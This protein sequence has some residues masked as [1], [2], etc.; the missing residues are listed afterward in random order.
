MSTRPLRVVGSGRRVRIAGSSTTPTAAWT[1]SGTRP[2]PRAPARRRVSAADRGARL[3][4]VVVAGTV[5]VLS[6]PLLVG[7][8]LLV[9]ATSRGGPLFRQLRIGRDEQPFVMYKFRTMYVGC[10]DRLHREYVR[11]VLLGTPPPVGA[12]GLY[13]LVD[14][15]RVTRLG[16]LLRRTSLDEL[17]QLLNVLRG[18]MALVGPRPVLPWE[19]VLLRP[20]HRA[21]FQVR[22]GITGLWQVSGR[23]RLPMSQA[24]DLDVQYVRARC[25]RLDV[26]LLLR[27]VPAV[28]TCRGAR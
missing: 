1:A 28:L 6:S 11:R 3:L 21:R 19:A 25:L 9:A 17:P 26:V 14:D 16:L 10:D 15:P 8:A 24:L 20:E 4:D 5:L 12:G 13:K 18:D 22:P 7:I 27:T 2:T 23:S